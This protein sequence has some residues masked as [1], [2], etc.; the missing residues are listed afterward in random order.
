[1]SKRCAHS[2]CH[3]SQGGTG[4]DNHS[5]YPA[6]HNISPLLFDSTK[7]QLP[8]HLFLVSSECYS[9]TSHPRSDVAKVTFVEETTADLSVRDRSVNQPYSA[10]RSNHVAALAEQGQL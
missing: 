6:K 7:G 4:S 2:E 10:R 3:S 9:V 1:M 5:P 8:A